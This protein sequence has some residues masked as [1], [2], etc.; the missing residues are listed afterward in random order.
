[1]PS[2]FVLS[3][4]LLHCAVSSCYIDFSDRSDMSFCRCVLCVNLYIESTD[5]DFMQK[6]I[7]RG[8]IRGIYVMRAEKKCLLEFMKYLKSDP[9]VEYRCFMSSAVCAAIPR[10]LVFIAMLL[11]ISYYYSVSS[12]N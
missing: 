5:N 12:R 3:G 8:M 6:M 9:E 11:S 1:M 4:F 2:W 10:L 7:L